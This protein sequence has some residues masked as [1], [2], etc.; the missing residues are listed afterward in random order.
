LRKTCCR[1]FG[2]LGRFL[3]TATAWNMSAFRRGMIVLALLSSTYLFFRDY[4][5]NRI[6]LAR[7]AR[8][9]ELMIDAYRF[10][11]EKYHTQLEFW[12]AICVPDAKR[13]EDFE[14][15]KN[16]LER[17]FT[18]YMTQLEAASVDV[19][20]AILTIARDIEGYYARIVE[21]WDKA[22]RATGE[23]RQAAQ[24]A[25]EELL[26]R[27]ELNK[28]V[29]RIIELQT[30]DA[31]ALHGSLR[32]GT[33]R[34]LVF[35]EGLLLFTA[36]LLGTAIFLS[37]R[38]EKKLF[39]RLAQAEKLSALG[40]L[41]AGVAHE[42]NNPL[43]FVRGFNNR[44]RSALR[45]GR[46]DVSELL[47]YLNEVDEGADRMSKI[48]D[49]LR[50]FSRKSERSPTPF[51][52]NT[53]IQRAFDFFDEQVRLRGI[54]VDLQLC[55]ADP[56]VAGF[57]NR[58]EQVVINLITNAR[59]AMGGWEQ[60]Q[61]PTMRVSTAVENERVVVRFADNGPGIPEKTINRI[62]EPFF[63]TKETGAGTGLGLSI[64]HE[65]VEEH[66]GEISV[67]CP[68]G[69][70]TVFTITMPQAR[71]ASGMWSAR[72]GKVV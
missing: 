44:A 40:Q 72:H 53:A 50:T 60:R 2:A 24:L 28:K 3:P 31:D 41:S 25:S 4:Q 46:V 62:F 30:R 71:P 43:T 65:I 13:M 35:N 68:P 8:M 6:G 7:E 23:D 29:A 21:S 64:V 17:A 9:S 22:L 14:K 57:A 67:K 10:S 34:R 49:H 19:D 27:F 58:F 32:A 33:L 5:K 66:A 39:H 16:A 26:D 51:S 48:I 12:E 63:T 45:K 54:T 1:I 56:Q 69:Q 18:S 36:L 15:H 47:D 42:L 37:V 52:V 20:P 11:E 59:D 55:P 61:T 38:R 70:G